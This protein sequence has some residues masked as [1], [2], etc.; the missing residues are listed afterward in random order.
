MQ[1]Y[2]QLLIGLEESHDSLKIEA[3][4]FMPIQVIFDFLSKIAIIQIMYDGF[5]T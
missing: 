2:Q 5:L 3:L 1:I 4:V